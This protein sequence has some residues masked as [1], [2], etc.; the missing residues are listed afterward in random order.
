[1]ESQK[2]RKTSLI[3]SAFVL[4]SMYLLMSIPARAISED[5]DTADVLADFQVGPT[6]TP[7]FPS[8]YS[9]VATLSVGFFVSGEPITTSTPSPTVT[10]S[11]S[12]TLTPVESLF[13]S[14]VEQ[15]VSKASP[16][17]L[18][19][20]IPISTPLPSPIPIE[21]TAV[22]T[23]GIAPTPLSTDIVAQVPILMYHYL[24]DPPANADIYRVDLS[25]TPANFEAQ[26]AYLKEAG[27]TTI[28]MDDL[29]EHLAGLKPLPPKPIILT[30]DDGYIDNYRHAYP[31]LQKYGF[32]ATF[33][34]ATWFIDAGDPNY[35][36]WDNVREMDAGG[37]KFGGHTY[38]HLDLRARD[39]DFLVYEIVGSKEAIEERIQEPVRHFVYPAG[40]YDQLVIDVLA[41]ANF[42]TALTIQYGFEHRHST[43]YELP[44]IRMRGS[45]TIEIFKAKV[46]VGP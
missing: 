39:V 13:S 4:I 28:S 17:S 38:R 10:V 19:S 26:L 15:P 32:Q 37:M 12:P 3:L 36:S 34:L 30:F 21:P 18:P 27:F 33:F 14:P 5:A 22:P 41:S 1:M 24:S 9:I 23:V 20:P 16:T 40:K 8:I 2:N 46:N 7:T 44:R 42:W 43:R 25:V 31:L 11:P 29:T 45:D 6:A 35:M